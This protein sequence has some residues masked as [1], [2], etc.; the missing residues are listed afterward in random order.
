M[1]FCSMFPHDWPSNAIPARAIQTV[2]RTLDVA[3]LEAWISKAAC[4]HR[5]SGGCDELNVLVLRQLDRELNR[6]IDG[7]RDILTIV[8]AAI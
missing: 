6:R 7:I 2:V 8:L 1:T 5:N 4:I 3:H